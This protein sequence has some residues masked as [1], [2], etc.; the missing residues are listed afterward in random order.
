MIKRILIGALLTPLMAL[1]QSYPSPTF[2]NLTVNG[3]FTATGK[4]GLGSLAS[5]AANTAVA[6]VT[7]AS[8]SP[9][10]VSLPSCSAANSAMQ[11]TSGTGFSCGTS[12]AL[13]TGNLGQFSSTTS[14]QLGAIISDETGSGSLVFGTNPTISGATVSGGTLN[15]TP[16]GST[17][18]NTGAFTTLS[19][20]STVSGTGFS[21]YLASPPAIG[22]TTAAAGKF[23]TL[24]AT[25]AI[26]P[27]TTAGVVGT[28]AADSANAGSVGEF[29]ISDIP[30]ASAVTLTSGTSA[31]VTSITLSAGDWDVSGTIGFTSAGSTVRSY[32]IGGV[33]TT[34]ATLPIGEF[35]ASVNPPSSSAVTDDIYALP[36]QRINVSSSTTVYLVALASF[37]TSTCKAYGVIRARRVR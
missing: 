36:A 37:T 19:A 27:S 26:T 23:T 28:T 21:T 31:N 10:A 13:T 24:Q 5:Q 29:F 11:Y 34:T 25:G 33:S 9:T 7:A 20:S 12:F 3:V 4:V 17:T 6:N 16:I 14:A 30:S 8:A 1:A 35:R 15:N 18:P 2:N 32:L 22:T